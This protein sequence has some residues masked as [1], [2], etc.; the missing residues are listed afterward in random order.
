MP[1]YLADGLSGEVRDLLATLP[2]LFVI[3][4]SSAFSFKGQEVAIP[5]IGSRLGAS[6]ILTGAVA[7]FG[8]GIRVRARLLDAGSSEPLWSKA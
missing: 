5:E 4:R 1:D 6:H 3:A 8:N 2:E 7:Q